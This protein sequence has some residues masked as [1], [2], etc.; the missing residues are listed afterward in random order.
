MGDEILNLDLQSIGKKLFALAENS[1]NDQFMLKVFKSAFLN[2]HCPKTL[3]ELVQ[4]FDNKLSVKPTR[5]ARYPKLH[6][7]MDQETNL[8]I[9]DEIFWLVHLKK[10]LAAN[11]RASIEVDLQLFKKFGE[12]PPNLKTIELILEN[13]DRCIELELILKDVKYY[14]K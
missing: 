9:M 5:E 13:I 4:A 3:E 6:V 8:P 14:N 10:E 7:N 11:E 12:C 1:K 2:L